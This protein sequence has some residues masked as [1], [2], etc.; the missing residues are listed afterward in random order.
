M[1]RRDMHSNI[2]VVQHLAAAQYSTTQTPAAGVDLQGFS[3]AEFVIAIGNV[4]T[5]AT[6]SWTFKLQESD[7]AGTGFTDVVDPGDVLVASA[8]VP[9]TTPDPTTGV[10]LT[11]DD[12]A[13][14][15]N[16]YRV[17]YIGTKRYVRVVATAVAT[18]GNTAMSIV[19]V[20]GM[21]AIAPTK[22][23]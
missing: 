8:K 7:S 22:D 9:V 18:P 23:A 16:T 15:E 17:G 20:L 3:A 1:I 10:F 6:A 2:R 11:V 21:P 12:A 4:P 14:D 13:E 5:I 19:A